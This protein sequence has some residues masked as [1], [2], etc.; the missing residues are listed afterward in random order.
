MSNSPRQSSAGQWLSVSEDTVLDRLHH[1]SRHPNLIDQNQGFKTFQVCFKN[2]YQNRIG[3]KLVFSIFGFILNPGWVPPEVRHG[4][5][6][7][8]FYTCK[9]SLTTSWTFKNCLWVK[10]FW[11]KYLFNFKP[12]VFPHSLNKHVY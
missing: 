12:S 2:F 11:V 6:I 9:S 4:P 1:Q 7:F 3:Q 10:W 8:S 5:F